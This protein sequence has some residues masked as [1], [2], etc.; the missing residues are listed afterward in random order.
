MSGALVDAEST[1]GNNDFP[2]RWLE[3]G[4]TVCKLHTAMDKDRNR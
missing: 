2:N 4:E 3:V 1:T